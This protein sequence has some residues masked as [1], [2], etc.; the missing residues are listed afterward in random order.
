LI[1][2]DTASFSTRFYLRAG[3]TSR[4]VLRSRDT[5]LS[6]LATLSFVLDIPAVT[7]LPI[8]FDIVENETQ[9]SGYLSQS[10]PVAAPYRGK[11]PEDSSGKQTKERH[12]DIPQC[13]GAD[14]ENG[15][16]HIRDVQRALFLQPFECFLGSNL[17]TAMRA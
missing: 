5:L 7:F 16:V 13:F 9:T 11:G 6:S 4:V 12:R 15:F 3:V 8:A 17:F 10:K 2:G 1:G 14:F